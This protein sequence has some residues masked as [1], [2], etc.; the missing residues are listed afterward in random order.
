MT[1]D[2]P[3]IDAPEAA[4]SLESDLPLGWR[5]VRYQEATDTPGVSIRVE[6][7]ERGGAVVAGPLARDGAARVGL[8]DVAIDLP[9]DQR[10]TSWT[11]P[12]I[13]ESV[14]EA[15]ELVSGYYEHVPQAPATQRS[16]LDDA[17]L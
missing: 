5:V 13:R 1:G 17:R 2:V 15:A 8:R 11:E 14:L 12:A 9:T 4:D 10:F 3:S 7:E 6:H 16:D